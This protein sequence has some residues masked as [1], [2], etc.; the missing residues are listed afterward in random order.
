MPQVINSNI[1]S[2]NA[3]RNLNKS[4]A[5]LNNSLQRLSSGLRI[6]SAKDDA[7]GLAIANRFTS[8]IRGLDQA[9]RNA[10]DAIS[11]SQTAEGAMGESTNILQRIRELSIQSANSTNSAQDRLSLQS[12]VNQLV[13][14]MDRIA[15]TTTFNGLKLLDG[16]FTAQSFQVG[17]NANQTVN[18]SV[19]AADTESLGIQ[20]LESTNAV[21]G[22]EMAT[23]GQGADLSGTG[24]NTNTGGDN[25]TALAAAAVSTQIVTITDASG[26]SN[27]GITAGDSAAEIAT[28]FDGK[29]GV[30]VTA[31]ENT[32]TIDTGGGTSNISNGDKIIFNLISDTGTD[33]V[34]FTRDTTTYANLEDQ[35]AA[36]LTGLNGDLVATTAANELTVTSASGSNIGIDGLVVE[37]NATATLTLPALTNDVVGTNLD[38]TESQFTIGDEITMT[39]S[40]GVNSSN[41]SYVVVASDLAAGGGDDQTLAGNIATAF[42]GQTGATGLTFTATAGGAGDGGINVTT[43]A[44]GSINQIAITAFEVDDT[45]GGGGAAVAGISVTLTASVANESEDVTTGGAVAAL[46]GSSGGVQ[47]ALYASDDTLEFAL[48]GT[49]VALDYAIAGGTILDK[50]DAKAVG[51]ALA[52]QLNA[53]VNY[54]AVAD[55]GGVIT[56]S[57][58]APAEF[59]NNDLNLTVTGAGGYT[60]TDNFTYEIKDLGG[61][62]AILAGAETTAFNTNVIGADTITASFA[63]GTMDVNNVT[64]DSSD[65]TNDSMLSVAGLSVTLDSGF[66]L[67]STQGV[68]TGGILNAVANTNVTL[69]AGQVGSA[70][71]TAGNNVTT[72]VLTVTGTGSTT[73]DIAADQTAKEIVANINQESDITGVE[74]TA[75]TTATISNLSESG[76]ISMTLN[77][78]DI[79]A[80]VTTGDLSSLVE[81]INAVTSQ[82]GVVAELSH[83]NAS[84][85]LTDSTG[86]DIDIS[87]FNTSTATTAN[88]V[89]IDVLGSEGAAAVAVTAGGSSDQDSTVVGGNI[90]FKSVAGPFTV[91]SSVDADS[92]GLFVGTADDLQA[93]QKQTVASI[94]I[95]TVDG[96]QRAIDITTGALAS[97][98]SSRADLGAIQN[99][100]N[101]T[102][103]NLST[104]SENLSA[105]RSRIQDADFAK[106]TTELTRNQIM[107]QAGM[108]I[109]AQAKSLPQQV[110]S[111]LQ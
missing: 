42:A 37:K 13:S 95:T 71:V 74:A 6:N 8:Q 12:E 55:A 78:K 65:P 19:G 63:A 68:S 30:T 92:G 23:G 39:V 73:V 29:T 89:S 17:A 101:S 54:D 57:I 45:A 31:S 22:I 41:F 93:S 102:V 47:A 14:E 53:V 64:L 2:L 24:L 80:N 86:N 21:K 44:A 26:T 33:A 50:S 18:V 69:T 35:F 105:A 7:A 94:D 38:F 81:S 111:L 43:S 61:V 15:E 49:D 82:T 16:S 66:D 107:M 58:D 11:L 88:S 76:V 98:D 96:A 40:D 108:S 48:S 91:S 25:V 56:V 97:I 83:D 72:Q 103:S 109:L 62:N 32:M 110:L 10:N 77:N 5:G 106:E 34:S 90:E 52:V 27:V 100:M 75:T 3:Q 99:R 104:T 36:V 60:D 70:N 67:K 46:T 84:M 51:D 9:V 87:N 20:K 4:Q 28:K 85:T 59:K 79:S 1:P